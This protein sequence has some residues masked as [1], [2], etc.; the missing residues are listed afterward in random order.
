[1]E[2]LSPN[3]KNL[4]RCLKY[5]SSLGFSNIEKKKL[6]NKPYHFSDQSIYELLKHSYITEEKHTVNLLK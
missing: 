5:F 2:V 4:L 1:M 3:A 6:Y